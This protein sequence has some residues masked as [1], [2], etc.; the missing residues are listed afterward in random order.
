MNSLNLLDLAGAG[1]VARA[2]PRLTMKIMGNKAAAQIAARAAEEAATGNTGS[3]ALRSNLSLVPSTLDIIPEVQTEIEKIRAIGTTALNDRVISQRV[4]P[5]GKVAE[6]ILDRTKG[7]YG[8]RLISSKFVTTDTGDTLLDVYVGTQKGKGFASRTS[9]TKANAKSNNVYEVVDGKELGLTGYFLKASRSVDEEG[10]LK[11]TTQVAEMGANTKVNAGWLS[12]KLRTNLGAETD[13]GRYLWSPAVTAIF[14]TTKEATSAAFEK[15]KLTAVVERML[16]PL[17]KLSSSK[18]NN[19]REAIQYGKLQPSR[20]DPAAT[21]RWLDYGELD[22]FYRTKFGRGITN[23]EATGYYAYKEV[24][25][26]AWL[27]GNETERSKL[28]AAG[29]ESFSIKGHP[30]PNVIGRKV[31]PNNIDPEFTLLTPEGSVI[32][33]AELSADELKK[34]EI[35]EA[36]GQA[37]HNGNRFTHLLVEKNS[38][39]T[40]GLQKNVLGYT[41]GG[42]RNYANVWFVKQRAVMNLGGK[43][44]ARNP[45]THGVFAT[46]QK[47]IE[48]TN[49]LN[50]TVRVYNSYVS[51]LLKVQKGTLSKTQLQVTGDAERLI[52]EIDPSM[53]ISKIEEMV[54]VGQLDLKNP[55]EVVYDRERVSGFDAPNWERLKNYQRSGKLYYSDRGEHLLEDGEPA[56]LLDPYVALSNQVGSMIHSNAY[57]NF[58][59]REV[60]EWKAAFGKSEWYEVPG[61]VYPSA[62]EL[63]KYGVWRGPNTP[64]FNRIRNLAESQRMYIKRVLLQPGSSDIFISEA[65]SRLAQKLATSLGD[66]KGAPESVRTGRIVTETS[67]V[68]GLRT[69]AYDLALGFFNIGQLAVQGSAAITATILHPLHGAAAIKDYGLIRAMAAADYN[70]QIIAVMDKRL[71]QSKFFGFKKGEF[72]KVIEDYRRSGMH[73][74]GRTDATL[75]RIGA[76]AVAG[77]KVSSTYDSVREALR[78]PLY[79]GERIGR[80][81]SFGIARREALDAVKAGRFAE[82]SAEYYQLIQKLSNKYTLNMMSGMETWWQRNQFTQ[83]PLQFFQYPFKYMEVFLGMNKEFTKSERMRFILG[84][85]FLYGAYGVPMGPEFS[86]GVLAPGY[87][88]MTGEKMNEETYQRMM[89]GLMDEFSQKMLGSDTA[90]STTFGSGNFIGEF[91][92]DLYGDNTAIGLAGGVSIASLAKFWDAGT[93][94]AKVWSAVAFNE[95]LYNAS[96]ELISE[97]TDLTMSELG[98]IVRS[99]N[100]ANKA[101][102]L[103][104]YGAL[105]DNRG[106]F[107]EM[108]SRYSALL[109]AMG[110]RSASEFKFWD[111]RETQ[112]SKTNRLNN[113]VEIVTKLQIQGDLAFHRDKDPETMGKKYEMANALVSA[114]EGEDRLYIIEQSRFRSLSSFEEQ[115][116]KLEMKGT[117]VYGGE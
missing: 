31:N 101:Y 48:Y 5:T 72:A 116:Q 110:I 81:V 9:A 56:A 16:T 91:I 99:M 76:G 33:R 39:F 53:S 66:F 25:D 92:K 109:A 38:A 61:L 10:F 103:H 80:I 102:Y 12:R 23:E 28:L 30:F 64:E 78:M 24:S 22:R 59:I 13:F 58:A 6:K 2:L 96:P 17:E 3:A 86:K 8:N 74:V 1:Q 41:E 88:Q 69:L 7:E 50:E 83:L 36:Y 115:T 93:D 54:E 60:G 105:L 11:R 27:V 42:T 84:H 113:V 21:G 108:D 43:E 49:N 77:G 87:E 111:G 47:A 34:Y 79:E 95:G 18:Q 104:K 106:G 117:T 90:L 107:V 71:A 89:L 62:D 55:L 100:N 82:E 15:A 63:V 94:I 75:D 37:E 40:A 20:M 35:I 112:E 67:A 44:V 65:K 46:K 57:R 52:Q 29:A 51:D 70:P 32:T 114:F 68:R 85:M 26:F 14:R 4:L 73:L 97:A 19:L 98:S 45:L